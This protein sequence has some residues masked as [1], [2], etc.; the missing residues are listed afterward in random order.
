MTKIGFEIVNPQLYEQIDL[1]RIEEPSASRKKGGIYI[2][3]ATPNDRKVFL[4]EFREQIFPGKEYKFPPVGKSNQ[5]KKFFAISLIDGDE[6]EQ[7]ERIKM[8]LS[9]MGKLF[10]QG[11]FA[12]KLKEE[13]GDKRFFS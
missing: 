12:D 10:S 9:K 2:R 4:E 11:N 1:L 3:F 6:K 7:I 13:N 5:E 8:V